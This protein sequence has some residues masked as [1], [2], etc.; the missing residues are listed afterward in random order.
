MAPLLGD[1]PEERKALKGIEDDSWEA[2][3]TT[4]TKVFPK[5]LA[6]GAVTA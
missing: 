5:N 4:W 3:K 1:D 6:I 2:G